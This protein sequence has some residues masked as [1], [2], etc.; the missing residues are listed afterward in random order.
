MK[1]ALLRSFRFIGA[2]G[3]ALLAWLALSA[4]L[5]I[6]A[7][8]TETVVV[9]GP[10]QSTLVALAAANGRLVDIGNG[11]VR[12][13]SA[14]KGLVARLYGGGAM[15]VLPARPGGCLGWSGRVRTG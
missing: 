13:T 8:P 2:C 9:I 7:E 10:R 3:V 15:L 6:V 14:E 5:T 4:S 11:F 1:A 12:V